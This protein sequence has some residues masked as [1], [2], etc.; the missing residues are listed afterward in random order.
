MTEHPIEGLMNTAMSN[1]RQ[2]IDVNTIIGNPIQT[3]PGTLIV[4]V[5]KVSFG[6]AS[7]GAEYDTKDKCNKKISIC[8][9]H[10]LMIYLLLFFW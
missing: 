1:I 6:F 9:V 4:P 2:M 3:I 5:S 7:G 10:Y 8:L